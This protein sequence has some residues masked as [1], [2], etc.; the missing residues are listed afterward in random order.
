MYSSPTGVRMADPEPS[1]DIR[2]RCNY[3]LL[4]THSNITQIRNKIDLN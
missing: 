1:N 4:K 2:F 3:I